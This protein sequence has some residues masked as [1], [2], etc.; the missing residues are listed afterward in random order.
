VENEEPV[1]RF[2]A[3]TLT[4]LGY[5]VRAAGAGQEAIDLWQTLSN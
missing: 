4:E 3:E 2:V 1:R 5:D